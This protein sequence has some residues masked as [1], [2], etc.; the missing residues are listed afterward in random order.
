MDKHKFAFQDS[1]LK[2]HSIIYD[3][4]NMSNVMLYICCFFFAKYSSI[5]SVNT[6]GGS[7]QL[8]CYEIIKSKP[9]LLDSADMESRQWDSSRHAR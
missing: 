7:T 2:Y 4:Y 5:L 6:F 8:L 9:C 3:S 1:I